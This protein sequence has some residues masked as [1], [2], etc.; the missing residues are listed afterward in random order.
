[1]NTVFLSLVTMFNGYYFKGTIPDSF[2][3]GISLSEKIEKSG[4]FNCT[5]NG[6]NRTIFKGCLFV[7]CIGIDSDDVNLIDCVV[8]VVTD[9]TQRIV[10]QTKQSKGGW[11]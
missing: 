9:D 1:M 11:S 3:S 10:S 2:I 4:F 8:V 6:T 7:D 5:F